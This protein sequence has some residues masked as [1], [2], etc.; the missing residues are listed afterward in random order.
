MPPLNDTVPRGSNQHM[1]PL[2]SM[3]WSPPPPPLTGQPGEPYF[4][5]NLY[6]FAQLHVIVKAGSWF[7]L[8]I[9]NKI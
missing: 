8:V 4:G 7:C 9:R 1:Y 6:Q 5:V 2:T 3:G